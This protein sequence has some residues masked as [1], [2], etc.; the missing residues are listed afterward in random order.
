[1][2]FAGGHTVRSATL[3]TYAFW[4]T[5]WLNQRKPSEFT[6]AASNVGAGRVASVDA[7]RGFAMF[8]IITGDSFG[9]VLSEI[10]RGR[11]GLF[12]SVLQSVGYE[13]LHAPWEGFRFYDLL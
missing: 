3:Q 12:G 11:P 8:W 2:G 7:L 6:G 4:S 10:G 5:G 1:M 13:F 9:W